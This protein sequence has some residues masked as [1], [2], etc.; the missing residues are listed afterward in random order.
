MYAL[1]AKSG[2]IYWIY[3]AQAGVRSAPVVG[4]LSPHKVALA[5]KHARG[6]RGKRLPAHQEVLKT[7]S[8]VFFGDDFR[9]LFIDVDN[10]HQLTI[11]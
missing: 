11:F 7:P 10:P 5:P 6:S 3:D 1:D 9:S 4:E 8:A 2:C